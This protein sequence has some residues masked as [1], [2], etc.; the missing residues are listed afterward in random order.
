MICY[1][2]LKSAVCCF[3][4]SMNQT[5][6][7]EKETQNPVTLRGGLYIV[8]TPIGNLRDITLRALDI[9]KSVDL[10]LCE[11]TRVTRKLLNAYQISARVQ[12]YNDYSQD[13]KR[14]SIIDLI[15]EGKSVALLSDA[16]MP[17]I[18]DPGFKLVRE[19]QEHGIYVTSLPGANAPLAALQLSAMPSDKF[20]FLGFMPAKSGVRQKLLAQW[21]DVKATIIAFETAPRLISCLEDIQSAIGDRPVAVI[22]EIT[23]LYEEVKKGSADNLVQYYRENGAPKGEIVLVIAPAEDKEISEGDIKEMLREAL[24]TMKVKAAANHVAELTG[25]KKSDLYNM[26]LEIK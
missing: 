2:L 20:C 18:S 22:R 25:A 6:N 24:E 12:V 8:A 19:C 14:N 16:G 11:D 7:R 17:L 10:I 4:M 13:N 3:V 9:L 26:A 23:K 5:D 1:S 21:V 15:E